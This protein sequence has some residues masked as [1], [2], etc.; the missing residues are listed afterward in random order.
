[1]EPRWRDHSVNSFRI[2]FFSF[3]T[4][5]FFMSKCRKASLGFSG[6]MEHISQIVGVL[7]PFMRKIWLR[8]WFFSF[9][10]ISSYH[11]EMLFK[12]LLRSGNTELAMFEI[13]GGYTNLP[14]II[15]SCSCP[16]YLKCLY[17]S[18]P[19]CVLFRLHCQ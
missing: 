9:L 17:E 10:L 2:W 19:I 13:M 4:I 8:Y 18:Y 14:W 1:M 11:K 12:D 3:F 16:D 7:I 5:S 15:S 6:M